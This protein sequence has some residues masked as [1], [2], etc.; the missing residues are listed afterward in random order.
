MPTK[1]DDY[2]FYDIAEAKKYGLRESIILHYLRE[3]HDSFEEK[4]ELV[5]DMFWSDQKAIADY[6]AISYRSVSN[7]VRRLE[8]RGAISKKISY[9]PS[10]LEVTTWWKINDKENA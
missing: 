2:V 4:G 8:K 9:K 5:D 3:K 1:K 10:S 6:T 7:A